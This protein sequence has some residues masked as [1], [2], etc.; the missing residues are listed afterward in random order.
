MSVVPGLA[1]AGSSAC[2]APSCSRRRQIEP[3]CR[4]PVTRCDVLGIVAGRGM[5]PADGGA[6]ISRQLGQVHVG[7][8]RQLAW[9]TVYGVAGW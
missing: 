9:R 8:N 5:A 6:V 2:I 4:S 3:S 1:N 7:A